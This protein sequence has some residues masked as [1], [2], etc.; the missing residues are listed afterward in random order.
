MKYVWN[1]SLL[2]LEKD[3]YPHDRWSTVAKCGAYVGNP[4]YSESLK[5]VYL[6]LCPKCFPIPSAVMIAAPKMIALLN[7]ISGRAYLGDLR[8]D[9]ISLLKEV[10][11]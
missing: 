3:G 11:R 1:Y 2:H 5:D 10:N 8:G 9:I 4:K 7:E 6:P